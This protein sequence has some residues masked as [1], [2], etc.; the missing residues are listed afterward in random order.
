[1]APRLVQ[2][3]PLLMTWNA[4][5]EENVNGENSLNTT[6]EHP[7]LKPLVDSSVLLKRPDADRLLAQQFEKDGYLFIRGLLDRQS[8]LEARR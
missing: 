1:M 6:N 4:D 5:H 2:V 8:V 7:S 3:G